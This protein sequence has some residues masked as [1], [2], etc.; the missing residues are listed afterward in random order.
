MGMTEVTG[1]GAET[2]ADSSLSMKE[3]IITLIGVL[4]ETESS[5]SGTE[6][7][8]RGPTPEAAK[9][10]TPDHNRQAESWHSLICEACELS[11]SVLHAA[12]RVNEQL[13]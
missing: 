13:G 3:Q 1:P 5:L 6:I 4:E 10:P 9:S 11:R 2:R 8:L 12:R 7:V